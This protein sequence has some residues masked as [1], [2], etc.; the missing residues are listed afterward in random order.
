MPQIVGMAL[1]IIRSHY[2]L[3]ASLMCETKVKRKLGKDNLEYCTGN[4]G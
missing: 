3:T 4:C 2:W 1:P